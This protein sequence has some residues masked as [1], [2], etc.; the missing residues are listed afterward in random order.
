MAVSLFLN[1]SFTEEGTKPLRDA[2]FDWVMLTLS[3][4]WQT[5]PLSPR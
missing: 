1:I 3:Q 2:K 5:R 4:H